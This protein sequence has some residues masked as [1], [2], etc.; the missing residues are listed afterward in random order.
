MLVK[1]T[2]EGLVGGM[3]ASGWRIDVAR[4]FVALPAREALHRTV[5]VTNP[6]TGKSVR[7]EVLDVGPWNIHDLKYVF[8]GARPLA[9]SGWKVDRGG[10]LIKGTTNGA[11]IDLGEAV[12]TALGMADNTDVDWVF[13]DTTTVTKSN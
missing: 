1:A 13:C 10:K 7:A 5:T 3:T 2:R 6:L 11:G 9:E 4:L 8:H 12:W